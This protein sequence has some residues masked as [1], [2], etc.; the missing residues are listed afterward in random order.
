MLPI[1]IEIIDNDVPNP[2]QTFKIVLSNLKLMDADYD[3][4]FDLRLKTPVTEVTI[5]DDDY[6]GSF[7][8]I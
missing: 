5:I 8:F 6:P 7:Q 1:K 2:D 3:S 4:N